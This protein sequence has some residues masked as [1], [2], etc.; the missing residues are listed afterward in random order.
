MYRRL[1][2]LRIFET[3]TQAD[4]R[5][6]DSLRYI[7]VARRIPDPDRPR[8]SLES[9]TCFVPARTPTRVDPTFALR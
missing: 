9:N 6:L 4:D 1:S 5:R 7:K 8:L 3:V 2:S